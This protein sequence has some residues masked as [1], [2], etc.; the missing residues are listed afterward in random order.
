MNPLKA[1]LASL[2]VLTACTSHA[3]EP[4]GSIL[5]S[6]GVTTS[7]REGQP[8]RIVGKGEKLEVGEVLS[9][10]TN[11]FAVVQLDDGSRMTLR[12]GTVF[13]VEKFTQEQGKESAWMRLFK[14]GLR[15][16][17]GLI[18]KRNPGGYELRSATATI[19]I[20][21][22]DFDARLCEKDC[23]QEAKQLGGQ[24][25]APVPEKA[26][27]ARVALVKGTL[28]AA[29]PGAP[30]RPLASGSPIYSGDVVET[31]R[32]GFAV[33]AFR[34]QSR[35]TLQSATRFA[36]ENFHY[37][38]K[39]NEGNALF[40]LLRG[41]LRAITGLIGKAQPS[42]FRM[43]TATA[44]IGIR[45]TGFDA[46]C[47]GPCALEAPPAR[48][49]GAEPGSSPDDGLFVSTWDGVV[50]VLTAAGVKIVRVDEAVFVGAPN[51]VPRTLPALPGFMRDNPAPR[52]DGVPVDFQNLFGART[53]APEAPGFF[54]WV[55][56]GHINVAADGR[57]FDL[58]RNESLYVGV[59]PDL[60]YR[61]EA[62]PVF[63]QFDSTP[64][65]DASGAISG[66]VISPLRDPSGLS[67][68]L[69]CRM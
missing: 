41:G 18:G 7:Q 23:A 63:M 51:E 20:R 5:F 33:L 52:P 9:T 66:S 4:A 19:G 15:A 34:D 58:G 28:S 12:P 53:D 61:L 1:V 40:R 55:R 10:G 36:V 21:G 44:T 60:V 65:P 64:R 14:G 31:G 37:E 3:A 69:E 47:G 11:S 24:A 48:P 16:I 22:T 45:G 42:A 68:D 27:V 43:Q 57:S 59:T 32:D 62:P 13:T 56:D 2:V 54:V 29:A 8:A 49:P 38:A 6:Q 39:K 26:V 46:H 30:A 17:T 35:F 67:S 25:A 50:E